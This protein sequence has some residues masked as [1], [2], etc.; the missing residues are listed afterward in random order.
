MLK[1][2]PDMRVEQHLVAF[3][4][5]DWTCGVS[6]FS[7]THKGHMMGSGGK[8][9]PPTNKKFKVEL[10]TV[11]HWKNGE[12]VEEKLFYDLVGVMMQLGLM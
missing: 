11:A 10:V 1:T 5:G 2:F 8:T 12:I 4:Q 3:G 7:G 9:V 6:I